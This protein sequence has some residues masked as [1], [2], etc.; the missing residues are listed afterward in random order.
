VIPSSP[1]LHTHAHTQRRNR[2]A[3]QL[4]NEHNVPLYEYIKSARINVSFSYYHRVGHP[5]A[6][7]M[8]HRNGHQMNERMERTIPVLTAASLFVP[9]SK[10]TIALTFVHYNCT[11]FHRTLRKVL[12]NDRTTT[13]L[14]IANAYQWKA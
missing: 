2:N 8:F 9:Y 14:Y 5:F 13:I 10:I 6:T 12:M 4:D 1:L 3:L 7:Y 11:A